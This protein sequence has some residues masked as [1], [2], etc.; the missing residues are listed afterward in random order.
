MK[1]MTESTHALEELSLTVER[2]LKAPRDVVFNAWL[3]PKLLSKFMIPA[4]AVTVARVTNDPSVG[5]R[6]DIIMRSGARDLPHSGVY[7]EIEPHRRLVFTWHS[8]HS[9]E[10]STVT[11]EFADA[12][13]GTRVTLT[14]VRFL[15]EGAR[16]DHEGGWT[17]I[18]SMLD[19]HLT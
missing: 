5:G 16:S 17:S 2:T 4:K 8:N 19:T 13:E 3:D 6:F 18:L 12:P 14:Q 10:D 9:P 11:L 15:D 7:R 1:T